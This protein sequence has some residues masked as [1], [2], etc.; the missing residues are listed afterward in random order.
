MPHL[1]SPASLADYQAYVQALELERGFS[2]QDVLQKCLLLGEEVGE[3]FRAIRKA[4]GMVVDE[5]AK[6][7]GAADE[8]ADV[9]ILLCAIANRCG[10]DLEQAFRD[11]EEIN[12][13]RRWIAA[14]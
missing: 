10:V 9:L 5:T 14:A 7:G 12:K 8:M 11:K 13:R 2:D 1:V 3:L 6:I 4:Q